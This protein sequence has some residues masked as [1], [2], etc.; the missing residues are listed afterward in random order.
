[1]LTPGKSCYNL[2][3]Y[4]SI[5]AG[6]RDIHRS[7]KNKAKA[8]RRWVRVLLIVAGTLFVGLGILGIFIPL[9]PTTPFLLL[10]AVCYARS[11]DRFY[12]WLL[13]NRWFGS[14]IRNYLQK[15][16]IPLRAKIFTLV[17]LWVVIGCSVAFAVESFVVRLILVLIAI[18]VSVHV[19][20]LR[21]LKE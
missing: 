19:L 12:H 6:I 21:T 7:K 1:V 4:H 15:R 9:L 2:D 10:A 8:T 14:Y 16:G 11:S 20:S 5:E 17:L 3:V 13:Y 18:G